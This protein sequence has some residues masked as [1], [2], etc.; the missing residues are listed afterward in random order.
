MA[1]SS[2]RLPDQDKRDWLRLIRSNHLGPITFH[3]ILRYYGSAAEAIARLPEIAARSGG[4]RRIELADEKTVAAEMKALKACGA[5]LLAWGEPGYPTGL[6][7][8]DDAPPLLAVRG[9]AEAVTGLPGIAVVGARNA[10]AIGQRFTRDMA[11]ALAQQG[12]AVLSGL[13][14]GIDKAAHEGALAANGQTAAFI[15]TGIDVAFPPENAKL[16]DEIAERG[17][18]FAEM[19]PGTPPL[20][21]NFPRRNR[22]ISG[23]SQ[24]VLVVE[25]ALKSGSLITARM[26]AE[27]GR[28]VMA[29]PGS[30]LD[31]RC[32]GSNGL[33]RDGA[34]LI[35]TVED[36]LAVLGQ[37]A[38]SS[39]RTVS[40]MPKPAPVG[41]DDLSRAHAEI[42]RLLSPSPVPVDELVRLSGMASGLV[43]MVL[44]EK[45]LA[46][47]VLRHPGGKVSA[48]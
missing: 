11:G 3:H 5:T 43:Q 10:S 34:A 46:G 32:R 18:V 20:A 31:P 1:R 8:L 2:P 7:Q 39:P 45:E 26:A 42:E 23:A 25:A 21:Q 33:I 47:R 27:Q 9:N 37:P 29:V 40:A 12:F 14:R 13:A 30:P 4:K 35:E 38:Q 16:H 48:A 22:L 6:M 17:A 36:I 15:G 24:G 19:P 44:T 28:E 41:D